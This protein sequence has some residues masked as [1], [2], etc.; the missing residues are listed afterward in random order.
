MGGGTSSDRTLMLV[1]SYLWLASLVPFFTKKDDPEIQWHAKN[2]LVM[3][4]GY[5]AI[6]IIF[7]V[8]GHMFPLVGCLTFFVPCA[9][10]IAYVIVQI[11]CITKAVNGQRMRVPVLTDFAEKM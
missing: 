2:G 3:A 4:V 9:L 10:F 11:L 1:L 8:I 5:T 6:A 7:A